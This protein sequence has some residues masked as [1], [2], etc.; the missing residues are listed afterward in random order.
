MYNPFRSL[1]IPGLFTGR[2]QKTRVKDI[3]YGI[4]PSTVIPKGCKTFY[5][6]SEGKYQMKRD[7]GYNTAIL[8]LNEKNAIRKFCNLKDKS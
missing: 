1:G 3:A 5:F 4:R 8:A 6:N 7:S 2:G